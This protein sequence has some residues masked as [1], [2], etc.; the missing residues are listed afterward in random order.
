MRLGQR[1]RQAILYQIV[2]ARRIA[3]QGPRI[4]P[5]AGNF[6]LKHLPEISHGSS[7]RCC[8][9]CV[10]NHAGTIARLCNPMMYRDYFCVISCKQRRSKQRNSCATQ[11]GWNTATEGSE[12]TRSPK[13]EGPKVPRSTIL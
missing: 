6:L 2:G 13:P 9:S 4:A 8:L 12:N 7:L 1:P 3:R 10:A 5:Q 11:Y